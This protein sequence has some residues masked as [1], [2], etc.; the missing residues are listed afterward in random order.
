MNSLSRAFRVLLSAVAMLACIGPALSASMPSLDRDAAAALKS[1]YDKTPAARALGAKASGILVFPRIVKAGFVVGG[2]GGDG[3]LLKGGKTV[4]YYNTGALSIG[5]QA[6]A[7][8]FGYV[9]FFM[10]DSA[11]EYLKNTNGWEIGVGPSIV[12]VDSGLAR[13]L[14]TTTAQSDIYAFF[15]DQKG[16][17]AGA[18]LQGTKITPLDR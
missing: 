8:S 1:L 13:S 4:G 2:Q 14:S 6:G 7:Q 11:L 3:V 10:S 16:L 5:L 17:M 18:G 9:L 12:I 15:F